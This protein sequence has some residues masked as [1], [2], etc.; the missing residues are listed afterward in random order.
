MLLD[1]RLSLR[2]ARELEMAGELTLDS[3]AMISRFVAML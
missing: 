1:R 2:R 3:L